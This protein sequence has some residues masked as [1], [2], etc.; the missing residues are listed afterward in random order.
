M[1]LL[2]A[3]VLLCLGS[4]PASA[5]MTPDDCRRLARSAADAGT[6]LED[7]TNRVIDLNSTLAAVKPDG[8]FAEP[9]S[10]LERAR[11]GLAVAAQE[12]ALALKD[13]V[14]PLKECRARSPR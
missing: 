14:Q 1:R 4:V 12:Y 9:A 3:L 13:L 2:P 10:R 11:P 6:S 5:Q 8:K 7:F